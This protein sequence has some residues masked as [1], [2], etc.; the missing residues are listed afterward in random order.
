[1]PSLDPVC[2]FHGL[3]ASEHEFG[4]CL[5]CCLCFVTL[6]PDTCAVDID[7]SKVDVCRPCWELENPLADPV[8]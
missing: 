7:G 2:T 5:Y 4:R 6:T 8:G 3:R 1:M